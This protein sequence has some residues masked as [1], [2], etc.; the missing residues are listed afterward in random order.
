MFTVYTLQVISQ[1]GTLVFEYDGTYLYRIYR[2]GREV[3]VLSN[4]ELSWVLNYLYHSFGAV[5]ITR[6]EEVQQ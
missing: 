3:R 1:Q 6:I 2:N 4:S 5:T